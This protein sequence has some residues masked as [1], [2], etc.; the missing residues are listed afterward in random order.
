FNLHDQAQLVARLVEIVLISAPVAGPRLRGH[1]PSPPRGKTHGS[2]QR[3]RLLP[4]LHHRNEE[5][6]R[7]DVQQPF[8]PHR[9]AERRTDDYFAVIRRRG[10][11]AVQDGSGVGWGML[12]VDEEPIETGT[13][14]DLRDDG[15][16]DVAPNPHG[17]FS[18]EN[19]ALETVVAHG[20]AQSNT[21]AGASWL[22]KERNSASSGLAS[23]NAP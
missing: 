20:S 6:A 2:R 4:G 13:G 17:G 3:L 15:I 1:A 9:V 18:R 21:A 16:R 8:H 14:A 23:L 22:A 10:L 12:R 11:Q 19:P 5:V 7:P